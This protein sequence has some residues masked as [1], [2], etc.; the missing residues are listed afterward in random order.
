MK[1]RNA[2]YN[3]H[4]TIDCE[5]E[6]PTFGWIPFTAS[7]DDI[8]QYGKAVYSALITVGDIAPYSKPIISPDAIANQY[9]L[10]RLSEYPFIQDQLD[11]IYWDKVNGTDEWA[12]L[13][14][15]VKT[16]HPKSQEK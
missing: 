14:E 10:A 8:E 11:M 5:I 15:A 16:K 6:H 4:G 9:K 7:P 1:T 13:I 2:K 12:T 3:E